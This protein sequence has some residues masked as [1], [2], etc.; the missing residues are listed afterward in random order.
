MM[1]QTW[2]GKGGPRG[3]GALGRNEALEIFISTHFL[4]WW[5][6]AST[7]TSCCLAGLW[8]SKVGKILSALKKDGLD[9]LLLFSLP[10]LG[11]LILA[12]WCIK[13]DW[14]S[15]SIELTSNTCKRFIYLIG[16]SPLSHQEDSKWLW[17]TVL[18]QNK[19]NII[20]SHWDHFISFSALLV[21]QIL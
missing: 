13:P 14:L 7:L 19:K 3:K 21:T 2:S 9:Y 1:T 8:L 4:C 20:K 16:L 15:R 17:F 12:A 5:G 6:S 10:P 18:R 11:H